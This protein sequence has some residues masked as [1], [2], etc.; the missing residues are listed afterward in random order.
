MHSL[1]TALRRTTIE[2]ASSTR[3]GVVGLVSL[4][5][6]FCSLPRLCR[7]AVRHIVGRPCCRSSICFSRARPS[8][9]VSHTIPRRFSDLSLLFGSSICTHWHAN[10][11]LRWSSFTRRRS[12]SLCI[13]FI[14]LRA[15]PS[16]IRSLYY[17]FIWQYW[18]CP[19]DVPFNAI[20]N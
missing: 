10:R 17:T 9:S 8:R 7:L 1:R 13:A 2:H 19:R 6:H 5:I 12:F 16:F 20:K 15:R 4:Y 3:F 18:Y 11:L 14:T